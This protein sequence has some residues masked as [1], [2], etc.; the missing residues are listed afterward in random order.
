[1]GHLVHKGRSKGPF[2]PSFREVIIKHA[3][4]HRYL[5]EEVASLD[6]KLCSL[7]LRAQGHDMA[8]SLSQLD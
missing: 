4:A 6:L 5:L 1:M 7:P 3:T 2:S 8:L